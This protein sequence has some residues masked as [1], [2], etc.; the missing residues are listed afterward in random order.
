MFDSN[1]W[2]REPL[3]PQLLVLALAYVPVLILIFARNS[4]GRLKTAAWLVTWGAMAM[5]GEHG[6]IGMAL[7]AEQANRLPVHA[8]YHF[9]MASIYTF[10]GAGVLV[11]MAHTLL[12]AG[13][14]AGWF[15]VFVVFVVG[16]SFEVFSGITTYAH[17]LPPDSIPLGL[18]LYVYI[19]A[20]GSALAISFQPEF[21]GLSGTAP[22]GIG[23]T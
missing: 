3:I 13:K 23:D 2:S 12:R 15:T 4:I 16:S 8:R 14:R 20:W 9:F 19:I 10:I 5:V 18:A 7:L 22:A 11:L 6:G 21:I 1:Y 17:G